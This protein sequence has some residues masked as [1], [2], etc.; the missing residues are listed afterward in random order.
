M[1]VAICAGALAGLLAT[2]L[3]QL[4]TVPLIVAAERF[5]VS[6][7]L[8]GAHA[9]EHD[10]ASWRPHGFERIAATAFADVLT[11]IACAL[12][13]VAIWA[14][15]AAN[16]DGRRGA[17]WGL[18][19]FVAVS[20]APSLGLPPELPG[21]A[22]AALP[23]RQ[24][25]WIGTVLLTAVGLSGL[26]F[27]RSISVKAA[28]LGAILLPH[29]LGA[30]QPVVVA[31]LAPLALSQKFH[32]AALGSSLAF[33]IVLGTVSG[34]LMAISRRESVARDPRP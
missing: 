8:D 10:T 21:T 23:A 17:L 7:P 2:G 26:V 11:G 33:W 31:S 18:A 20:F 22:T 1:L 3:H 9:H 30:P 25:W 4:T 14:W 16:V 13:L 27:A 19:G 15:Q 24:I 5:E 34:Y 6:A 29:L 32:A 28:A 12:L